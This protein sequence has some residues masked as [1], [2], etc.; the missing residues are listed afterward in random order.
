MQNF[1]HRLIFSI[2]FFILGIHLVALGIYWN[3]TNT[4]ANP[5]WVLLSALMSLEW[6]LIKAVIIISLG[7][8]VFYIFGSA[9]FTSNPSSKLVE[10][11]PAVT[12]PSP[13]IAT[14]PKQ[15]EVVIKDEAPLPEPTPPTPEELKE[16]AINQ[17][18]R[19]Y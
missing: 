7:L 4:S 10:P 16:K 18:L 14:P 13:A 19:G 11:K 1:E 5:A 2:L 15:I 8:F 6:F 17:I 12:P 3:G 9:T